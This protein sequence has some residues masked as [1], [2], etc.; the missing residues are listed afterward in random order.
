MKKTACTLFLMMA[1]GSLSACGFALRGTEQHSHTAN[2][3]AHLVKINIDGNHQIFG[4][5]LSQKLYHLGFTQANSPSNQADNAPQIHIQNIQLKSYRLV[6]ILTEIRM[7]LT[8]TAH[9]HLPNGEVHTAPLLVE[10]SYQYNENNVSA[11]NRQAVQ[12]EQW[13]YE[14]LATRISEQYGTLSGAN[15]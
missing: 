1:L 14:S 13:L 10:R 2:P 7:V 3:M 12:V 8:A 15:R 11:S 6:G 5:R 4:E 9:Y